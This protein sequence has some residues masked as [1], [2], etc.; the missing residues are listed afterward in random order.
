MASILTCFTWGIFKVLLIV[1]RGAADH[2]KTRHDN[3]RSVF[4]S[5]RKRALKPQ[6][7]SEHPRCRRKP[8]NGLGKRF[9]NLLRGKKITKNTHPGCKPEIKW[10]IPFYISFP[11]VTISP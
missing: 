4:T 7:A 11:L 3:G 6:K 1:I 10:E 8:E 5:G 9:A 2:A